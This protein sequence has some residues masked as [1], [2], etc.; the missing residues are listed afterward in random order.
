MADSNSECIALR[1]IAMA[2]PWAPS[3]KGAANPQ[4]PGR[5]PPGA[6]GALATCPGLQAQCH[7]SNFLAGFDLSACGPRKESPCT[8]GDKFA[9]PKSSSSDPGASAQRR[10]GDVHSLSPFDVAKEILCRM[11]TIRLPPRGIH[12]HIVT[13]RSCTATSPLLS[14]TARVSQKDL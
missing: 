11:K 9:W 6:E 3:A 12:H 7:H 5:K 13:R 4:V 10:E 14:P 8:P 1:K 2:R